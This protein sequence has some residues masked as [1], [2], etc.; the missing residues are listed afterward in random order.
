MVK[1]DG[2][3]TAR[4]A[5]GASCPHCG[6][7]VAGSVDR[8]CCA[9]CETAAA[10]IAGAGLD[11][12]YAKREQPAPRPAAQRGDYR[13][14]PLEE[15][16]GGMSCRLVVDG[17]RCASCVWLVEGVLQRTEGVS[18][19][20]VSY[21]TGRAQILFDP[22]VVSIET[23]GARIAGLGYAP[24]AVDG[25]ST[26]DREWTVRLGVASFCAANVMLLSATVYTGWFEGME[27]RYLALFRW[28]ELALATPVA[29]YAASGFFTSA[30]RALS[31]G[32]LH[33]DLPISLAVAV[34]YGHGVWATLDRQD[35]YLDTLVMLVTLLLVGR[36]IEARGRRSAAT[37]AASIA[38]TLPT[39]ARR[40][41][42]GQ[43]EIV[44]VDRLEVGD[45]VE[46]GLGEEVPA[47]GV[48]IDGRALV[49]QALLTGESEP[50]A[51][52]AGER[53]VAGA[54]IVDGALSVSVEQTG[55][56]T[57]GQR[58]AREVMT[59]VD[60]GLPVTP[61]DRIAPW[62]TAGTLLVALLT[63][64]G[65][66]VTLGLDT[67]L[68]RT[69][70][71]LVVACPCA[72]GLS[73]PIAVS[74]GLSALAR[75]GLVLRD[76]ASL[77][78]LADVDLLALDKTGTVTGGVPRVV[79]A[80]TD[81]L[82]VAAGLERASH[83]PI[84][85]AIREAAID[86]GVRLPLATDLRETVGVGVEGRVDDVGY[87][88]RSGS[89][90][91]VELW[92]TDDEERIGIIGLA[93]TRR[94]DAPRVLHQIRGD[95][96]GQVPVV[97]LTGDHEAVAHR[98][99]EGVGG[100]EVHA[101]LTPPEKA[102]FVDRQQVAG[103]TVLFVGD[104]LNDGPALV[105]ADV[106]FAMRGGAAASVLVADGVVVD[107]ALAPVR[108]GM[109]AGKVVRRV[110]RGNMTRSVVYNVVAVGFAAA[111]F[112]DPLVAAVLMPLSSLLV[113]AG[114]VSVEGRLRRL[115]E[116]SPSKEG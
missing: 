14:L 29:I 12:W 84:A 10:I 45:R 56:A 106:G 52:G 48:V 49:R 62:F 116:R 59:S 101:G 3:R 58:M 30:W 109:L 73:W 71:V 74:H 11:E 75:R 88:L 87:A 69:V 65:T 25:P 9:G 115:G 105:K 108:W 99:A 63:S 111:G 67:A 110:V 70:A 104:G 16:D 55:D 93:D 96:D 47:D 46:V 24:R 98:I 76:G 103:R 54:E 113:I 53:V 91:T 92:R 68:E 81:V 107:D 28:T 66:T 27:A 1:V 77:L 8:Y 38:A 78:R 40:M 26:A 17:L 19:A 31:R 112:V 89:P 13:A 5:D 39:E 41:R 57:L 23:I 51:R 114:G 72:L 6:V 79:S 20:S 34:L 83:H 64:I 80:E 86:R 35:G 18:E 85:Q 21:A 50:V 97:L 44:P 32:V 90:G 95:H 43:V 100:L 94:D 2:A 42:D 82:R 36:L 61:A 15:T 7:A 4:R 33:M 60:R 37:A 102:A 22:E